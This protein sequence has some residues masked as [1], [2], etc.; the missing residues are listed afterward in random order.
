MNNRFASISDLHILGTN[1]V[2]RRDVLTDTQWKKLESLYLFAWKRDADVIISGDIFNGS[3]SYHL[4]KKM[5][6]FL[7]GYR[8]KGVNTYAVFGQHDLKYRNKEDTNL[9]ILSATGV[10][11]ILGSNP[12]MGSGFRVYGAGFN[13]VVPIPPDKDDVNI[14]V[15]HAAISPSSLFHGH[16]YISIKDFVEEHPMYDIVL[17]GDVHRTFIEEHNNTVV[18]NSGPLLRK[19]ADEYNMIHKPGFF[20]IDMENVSIEYHEVDHKPSA[21]V[22]SRSHIEKKKVKELSAAIADTAHFL[23]ELNKRSKGGRLMNIRERIKQRIEGEGKS[24]PGAKSVLECL[25][26]E[27][28]ISQWL[29]DQEKHQELQ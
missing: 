8:K 13:E 5:G 4:L 22:I 29:Q 15:I 27:R 1:P 16:H 25:L 14:L 26:N 24:T 28:N 23:D 3:N 17:C 18:I 11:G 21:E 9:D 6:Q 20:Y 7:N 2:S 19:E 10:V 12:I